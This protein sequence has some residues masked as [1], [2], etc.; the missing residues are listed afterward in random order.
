MVYKGKNFDPNYHLKKHFD[1]NYNNN[2][3]HNPYNYNEN[4]NYNPPPLPP[5]PSRRSDGSPSGPTSPIDSDRSRST[6]SFSRPRLEDSIDRRP[7]RSSSRSYDDGPLSR[8]Y[9]NPPPPPRY[10][11]D[12]RDSD[13]YTPS[14]SSS[15]TPSYKRDRGKREDKDGPGR[16][17]P[18]SAY[19]KNNN[20][21]NLET[22]LEKKIKVEDQLERNPH[23][24]QTHVDARRI[25]GDNICK[26]PEDCERPRTPALTPADSP[27]DNTK[28]EADPQQ[29][30][31]PLSTQSTIPYLEH[32]QDRNTTESDHTDNHH[33]DPNLQIRQSSVGTTTSSTIATDNQNPWTRS[34]SLLSSSSRP[35]SPASS[36]TD[37]HLGTTSDSTLTQPV[38]WTSQGES[39]AGATMERLPSER[40][41]PHQQPEQSLPSTQSGNI[42]TTAPSL[43]LMAV[44]EKI[45]YLDYLWKSGSDKLNQSAKVAEQSVLTCVL[46]QVLEEVR[47]YAILRET[48]QNQ[49]LN[50][51]ISTIEA[52][53]E[54]MRQLD[55]RRKFDITCLQPGVPIPEA[56]LDHTLQETYTISPLA[57]GNGAETMTMSAIQQPPIVNIEESEAEVLSSD[58]TNS[59]DVSNPR[60]RT[61]EQMDPSE[62]Q[63]NRVS[64]Y[65]DD[66]KTTGDTEGTFHS[67]S[68]PTVEY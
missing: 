3:Y 47:I 27:I 18:G 41:Q 14:S 12:K 49:D 1:R 8:R 65:Q 22:S 26:T 67:F 44:D 19:K 36:T 39:G 30:S 54:T 32:P 37:I 10:Y 56:P 68:L 5:P 63:V 2:I 31:T 64:K 29:Q 45:N 40:T 35:Q 21:K 23:D 7:E 16:D 17:D 53:N 59:T 34:P 6:R 28:D 58:Q 51:H 9:D 24:K 61:L 55:S 20:I 62:T 38:N 15:S 46:R 11:D 60:K 4:S 48:L 66:D 42:M 50:G 25:N 52:V 57:T 33:D 43:A 13:R